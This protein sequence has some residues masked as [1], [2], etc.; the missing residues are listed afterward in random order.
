[1]LFWVIRDWECSVPC[2]A[3]RCGSQHL[4]ASSMPLNYPMRG[5]EYFQ[6]LEFYPLL[7]GRP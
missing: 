1:R 7:N 6:I 4:T 3:W 2:K 5:S